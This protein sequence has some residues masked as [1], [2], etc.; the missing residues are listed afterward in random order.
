[1]ISIGAAVDAGD[2]VGAAG[3]IGA[4]VVQV[5][6][7]DPQTWNAPRVSFPGGAGGLR[8]ALA[9][10]GL[11][12]YVHSP[13]LINVATTN[14]RVRIPSRAVLQKTLDAAAQAGAAGVVVHGGHVPKDD[15][16]RAGFENW[17][18]CVDRLQLPV[19]LLIENT[20]GGAGAMARHLDRLAQLWQAL[21]QSENFA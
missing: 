7:S 2:P 1:M 10:A 19:P 20:A 11:A 12:L 18:K 4:Q 15:D 16:P 8:A 21:S 13:F 5:H 9:Q 14:S 3:A 6:L 17:L